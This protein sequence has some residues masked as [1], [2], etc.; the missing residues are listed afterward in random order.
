[1]ESGRPNNKYVKALNALE[2]RG[3]RLLLTTRI[4]KT[5][6]GKVTYELCL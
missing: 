5:V 2:D 4:W 6:L 1:M 3:K